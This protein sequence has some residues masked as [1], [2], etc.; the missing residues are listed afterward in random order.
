VRAVLGKRTGVAMSNRLGDGGLRAL[1]GRAVAI[2]QVSEPNPEFVSLPAPAKRPRSAGDG[3][4]PLPAFPAP[5]RRAADAAAIVDLAKARGVAAAGHIAT[6]E[7][8]LAVG[9]SLG[10][11]AYHRMAHSDVMVIMTRDGASGYAQW[12]GTALDD[13]P[14]EEIARRAT[15]K[16]LAGGDP[17]ALEPGSYTVILEPPAVAEMLVMLAFMGLGATPYQEGRSF[18]SGKLGEKLV[19]EDITLRDNAYYPGIITLPFD[20]EGMPKQAVTFFAGGVASG[21]VYDSYTA[22]KEGRESTGHALPAPN[23]FGPLPL[24]LVLEPGRQP[25][26]ELLRGV[27]RG[28]LVTRFHYVNIVHPKETILTG[29]TRDG[30]FLIEGGAITRPVKNL[31]FTQSVLDALRSVSGIEDA[32]TLVDQ[33]GLYCLAPTLRIEGFAFTSATA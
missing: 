6:G 11:R 2:A 12:T 31:R 14:V 5:E 10:V 1:V 30:T 15:D 27:E 29:M 32:L 25:R 24:H 19:G 20:Y 16:C 33:E 28:V 23:R 22:N 4:G 9:N 17:I 7:S 21:V 13:A 18:M 3:G 26:A 8:A